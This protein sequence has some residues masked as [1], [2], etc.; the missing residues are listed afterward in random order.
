MMRVGVNLLYLR[1]GEVGG[2][3]VYVRGLV[4]SLAE[5]VELVLFCCDAAARTFDLPGHEVVSVSAAGYRLDRRLWDENWTLRRHLAGRE[6][7][8]LF[9]PGNFAAPALPSRI[10]QVATVHDLQHHWLRQHFTHAKWLQRTVMFHAT[11][12]RCRRLIAISEFT[13]EDVIHRYRV[14]PGKIVAVLEGVDIDFTRDEALAEALRQRLSL[15]QRYF[16]FPAKSF[17]HKNHAR[18]V[19]AFHALQ[20]RHGGQGAHLLFSGERTADFEPVQR[21]I[22]DLG[23]ATRV[24]H[25]GYLRYRE[26]LHVLAMAEAMVFPSTFEGFGLPALEAMQCGV[27]VLA[28]RCTAIPEVCGDAAILVEPGD[29]RAWAGAME[30]VLRDAGLR[31]RLQD[32]GMTNLAR[33]S[34]NKCADETL[35]VFESC[36]PR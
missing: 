35:R 3:E 14:D 31:R 36:L 2:S 8:L 29:T 20:Q 32:A 28:S 7:D 27:P 10:P 5:R 21:R 23:L 30:R 33:F 1:P 9:S 17:P 25:L 12:R 6:L 22:D 4:R 16:F 34:W 18:L 24:R 11:F 19:E 26:V 15:P 13:R